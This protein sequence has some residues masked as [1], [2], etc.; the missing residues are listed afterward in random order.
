MRPRRITRL[1]IIGLSLLLLGYGAGRWH[2]RDT[3]ATC[4]ALA[5]SLDRMVTAYDAANAEMWRALGVIAR[6][7]SPPAAL[8]E[9]GGAQ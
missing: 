9:A 2:Q 4:T 3:V 7:E 8:P 6:A 5:G 1:A